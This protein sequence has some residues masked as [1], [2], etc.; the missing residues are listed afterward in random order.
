MA[1]IRS[2]HFIPNGAYPARGEFDCRFA[3]SDK[4]KDSLELLELDQ[5]FGLL[6]VHYNF[7]SCVASG[8]FRVAL[9]AKINHH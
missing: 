8:R 2:N 1:A 5:L 4:V 6:V 3:T 7:R 9:N